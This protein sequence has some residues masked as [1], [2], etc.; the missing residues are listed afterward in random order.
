L[1]AELQPDITLMDLELPDV[2]GAEATRQICASDG[3]ARIIILT[4]HQGNEDIF[5]ALHSGAVA[6]LF[7]DA[8]SVELTDTIRRVYAGTYSLPPAIAARLREREDAPLLTARELE[9]V[10]LMTSGMSN[11]TM[12]TTLGISAE[13]VHAHVR[14]IFAK[15]DV[16]DRMTAVNVALRRGLVHRR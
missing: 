14:N 7:K 9:V 4:V 12:A 11:K 10:N 16:T 6:Y 3:D 15:L 5:R 8:L 1:Y 2:N 13:T